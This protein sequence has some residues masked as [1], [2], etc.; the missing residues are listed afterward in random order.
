MVKSYAGINQTTFE[1]ILVL[2]NRFR[3]VRIEYDQR[4]SYKKDRPWIKLLTN[5]NSKTY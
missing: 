5:I 1:P 2:F 4:F 3:T